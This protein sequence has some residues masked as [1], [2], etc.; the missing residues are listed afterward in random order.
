MWLANGGQSVNGYY[1]TYKPIAW[2]KMDITD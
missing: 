1:A 2:D